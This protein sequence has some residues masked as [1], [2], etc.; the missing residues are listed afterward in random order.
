MDEPI[1]LSQVMTA[2]TPDVIWQ[3]RAELLEAGMGIHAKPLIILDE[4]YDFLNELVASSTAREYSHFAS[5]LD[6]AAV[7]G[8]ALQNL[9]ENED[10]DG[11]W[12]RFMMGAASEGLMVL[13]ARQYVKAWEEEMKANYNAAAWYLTR[14]YWDLSVDLQPDLPMMA[15]RQ[16]VE[17][18]VAPLR[19]DHLEGI[20]KAG[21]IVCLFQMLLLARLSESGNL[22]EGLIR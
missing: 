11:L 1:T 21:L 20:V 6:M 16:L 12:Q 18:L 14:E 9:M 7:A 17:N 4:F 19:D 5:K 2:P 15:R 13:A 8:V 10:G 3:L 22:N